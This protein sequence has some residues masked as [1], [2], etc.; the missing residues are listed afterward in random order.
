MYDSY[1]GELLL[2]ISYFSNHL[3]V[4]V[5]LTGHRE[6]IFATHAFCVCV[7]ALSLSVWGA[8]ERDLAEVVRDLGRYCTHVVWLSEGRL[9]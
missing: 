7:A 6:D 9:N 3:L 2:L 4:H 5:E 8:Q 1:L